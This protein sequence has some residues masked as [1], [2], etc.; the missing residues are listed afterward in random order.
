MLLLLLLLTL[1][2]L[3]LPL[4]LLN[5]SQPSLQLSFSLHQLPELYSLTLVIWIFWPPLATTLLRD[6]VI[7]GSV[8]IVL[9]LRQL[10]RQI[11]LRILL[12]RCSTLLRLIHNVRTALLQPPTVGVP[13]FPCCRCDHSEL[14]RFPLPCH[15]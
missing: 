4:L 2:L 14:C 1:L 6:P 8:S 12:S 5:F 15:E 3:N 11:L 9:L 7:Q 10:L 13:S